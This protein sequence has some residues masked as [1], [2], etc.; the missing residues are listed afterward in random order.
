[1]YKKLRGVH[2][3]WSQTLP[4]TSHHRV[5]KPKCLKKFR[6]VHQTV[7]ACSRGVHI[8]AESEKTELKEVKNTK[9]TKKDIF[10][11]V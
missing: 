10:T 11:L 2:P 3:P 4:C 1:M 8:T 6:G 9:K 7:E 5:K